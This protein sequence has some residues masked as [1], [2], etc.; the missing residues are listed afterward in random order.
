MIAEF[1]RAFATAL[2]SF[3]GVAQLPLALDAP[4]VASA[5][6]PSSGTRACRMQVWQLRVFAIPAVS[7][8]A[9]MSGER[10]G[11]SY[12]VQQEA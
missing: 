3:G 11:A 12:S 9:M 1:A 10:E 2:L 6:P 8:T 7:D 5:R 4:S